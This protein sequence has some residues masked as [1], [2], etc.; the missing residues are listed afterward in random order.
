MTT[1]L[2]PSS[3]SSPSSHSYPAPPGLV[4]ALKPTHG[5]LDP[6]ST[7]G[8]AYPS[9]PPNPV[10]ASQYAHQ[11]AELSIS[12]PTSGS[13]SALGSD[14]Y[15]FYGEDGEDE[16]GV[17]EEL[18]YAYVAPYELARPGPGTE[19]DGMSDVTSLWGEYVEVDTGPNAG[20]SMSGSGSL[21]G[22]G[23]VV[24]DLWKEHEEVGLV[25]R[26][27][28]PNAVNCPEHGV[29]KCKKGICSLHAKILRDQERSKKEEERR[30]KGRG[31]GNANAT[32]KGG[33]NPNAIPIGNGD[34]SGSW[35][36]AKP[37]G[38]ANANANAS[39][40]APTNGD[41]GDGAAGAASEEFIS[42][43]N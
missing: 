35:R 24:E 42:I 18:E 20:V 43:S 15:G 37:G 33:E 40:S 10:G 9:Y 34:G 8:A 23:E 16:Y 11:L 27:Q 29:G 12:S 2:D 39:A 41:G 6:S 31:R 32:A 36:K 5:V 17:G 38:N 22:E 19:V 3:P 30:G 25:I 21:G 1:P 4:R 26:G 14:P 13:R 7:A 28:R